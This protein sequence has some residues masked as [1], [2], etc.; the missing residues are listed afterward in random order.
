MSDVFEI[1]AARSIEH[2]CSNGTV[3]KCD[4]ADLKEKIIVI[5][6]KIKCESPDD[7]DVVNRDRLVKDVA[8]FIAWHAL[9]IYPDLRTHFSGYDCLNF[10]YV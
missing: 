4:R 9:C 2:R 10:E 3:F 1:A 6:D 8:E 5:M 7:E